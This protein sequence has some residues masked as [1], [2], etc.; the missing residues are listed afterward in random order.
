MIPSGMY[1]VSVYF[2]GEH[3]PFPTWFVPYDP[4]DLHFDFY[5]L[6]AFKKYKQKSGN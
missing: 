1:L 3:A 6:R 4:G 5:K 2:G